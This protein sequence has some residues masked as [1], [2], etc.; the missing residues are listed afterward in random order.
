M[1]S[2]ILILLISALFRFV[3]VRGYPFEIDATVR[4][5]H[6]VSGLGTRDD[7]SA[8]CTGLEAG[9]VAS[10]AMDILSEVSECFQHHTLIEFGR[11]RPGYRERECRMRLAR[12]EKA[13][14]K[15]VRARVEYT[16]GLV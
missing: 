9:D 16:Q 2:K 11:S 13:G 12:E 1:I 10:R 4:A 6:G 5:F 8:L 3:F 7:R 15:R 14:R